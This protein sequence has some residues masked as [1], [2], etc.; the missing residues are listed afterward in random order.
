MVSIDL[1]IKNDYH[2]LLMQLHAV[3]GAAPL[4]VQTPDDLA[5]L[6]SQRDR[7]AHAND[8]TRETALHAA[9]GHRAVH[10]ALKCLL[11]TRATSSERDTRRE[12]LERLHRLVG[13]DRPCVVHRN[14]QRRL[15]ALRFREHAAECREE[16]EQCSCNSSVSGSVP[17]I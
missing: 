4:A 11:Q 14:T 13:R 2:L 15:R 8:D 3:D 6:L 7:P 10:H 1:R 12:P 5:D 16:G 17:R 9:R